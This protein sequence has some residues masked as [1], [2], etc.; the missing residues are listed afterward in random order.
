MTPQQTNMDVIANNLANVVL[1]VL[2]VSARCLKICF[3]KP[4]ASGAQSSEQTTLPS[5]LQIG[6]GV[7]PVATERLH[8]QGNLSQ[9]NNSKDVAI[10]GQGFFQ[11]MLPD[12]SSAYTRDGSFQVDQ[13]GQLV[14]AGGFQVQPAITIP[15]NALSITIGRDGVV[16]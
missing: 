14:T 13:N 1:T 2:S 9:T 12:G 10:K 7:R 8:S 6:T 5:G 16:T 15:A 11:V 3:I 4:F